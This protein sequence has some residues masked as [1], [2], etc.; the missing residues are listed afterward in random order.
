LSKK[1]VLSIEEIDD[2]M[3]QLSNDNLIDFVVSDSKNGYF[4]CVDL[5]KNGQSFIADNKKSRRAFG[6]LV[7]RSIFLATVSFVFGIILKA[8]F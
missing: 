3:V 5:K 8:I 6:M 1:F 4:Y 7:L 2:I